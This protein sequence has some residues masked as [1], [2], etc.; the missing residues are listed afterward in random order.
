MVRD[1]KIKTIETQ[2]KAD[3]AQREL[4][5]LRS[6]PPSIDW[7][8]KWNSLSAEFIKNQHD[9]TRADYTI[10]MRDGQ[11]VH[12][13]W[14]LSG[15]YRQN[16]AAYCKLAGA[17]LISSTR[18]SRRLSELVRSQADPVWRWLYFLKETGANMSGSLIATETT[19]NGVETH[20]LGQSIN[21]V[22]YVSQRACIECA[23]EEV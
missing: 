9:D 14:E 1:E 10:R 23:A 21:R 11:V 2:E 22:A 5:E 15:A 16:C 8:G 17:M 4:A 13:S 19:N 7:Q 6:M 20:S 18:V 3:K 12:E